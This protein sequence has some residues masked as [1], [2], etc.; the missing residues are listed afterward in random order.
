MTVNKFS[1]FQTAGNSRRFLFYHTRIT[2]TLRPQLFFLY[3]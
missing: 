3:K 2:V 1:H